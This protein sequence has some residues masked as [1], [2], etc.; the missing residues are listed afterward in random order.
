MIKTLWYRAH[1]EGVGWSDWI[2]EEV[3]TSA[4]SEAFEKIGNNIKEAGEA[5]A[6]A[7]E[8]D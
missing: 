6:K 2:A 4:I 5:I 1:V 7:L 3:D 8:N